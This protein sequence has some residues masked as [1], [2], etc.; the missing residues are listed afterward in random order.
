MLLLIS[1]HCCIHNSTWAAHPITSYILSVNGNIKVFES[2]ADYSECFLLRWELSF[3]INLFR[4]WAFFLSGKLQ[5]V[6]FSSCLSQQLE[7]Q[8]YDADGTVRRK[9]EGY[10]IVATHVVFVKL[11]QTCDIYSCCLQNNHTDSSC[12]VPNGI[13]RGTLCFLNAAELNGSS[14][15]NKTDFMRK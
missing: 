10:F 15:N 3:S 11:R 4:F 1:H 9:D 7:K 2:V 5:K 14:E 8:V 13:K 6:T 12:R